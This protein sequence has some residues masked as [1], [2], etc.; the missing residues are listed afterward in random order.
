MVTMIPPGVKPGSNRSERE[1][2]TA[3]EG[4]TDRPDWI[5]LHSLQLANNL[6]S[7]EGE[8]D[9]IVFVPGKG[10]VVIET[11]SPKYVEYSNG[12]WY[13]D[14]LPDPTKDPLQQLSR[15]R[16][17][18]RGFLK[19]HDEHINNIPIA[20][21]L[22][23]TSIARHQFINNSIGDMQF[24]E[25]ELGLA[26]DKDKPAVAIEKLL[27]NHISFFAT[28]AEIEFAPKS[29]T[30]ERADGLASALLTNFTGFESS[31]E[32]AKSRYKIGQQMLDEQLAILELVEYNNHIYFD[33]GAGTGK[34]FLLGE[35]AK[36][37]AKQNKRTLVTC[38][39]YMMAEEL[40][41]SLNRPNI[42]VKD[43]NTLM[44]EICGLDSNPEGAGSQW[45]EDELPSMALEA[46]SVKPA[47]GGYEALCVDE[48]QDIAANLKLIEL[49]LAVANAAK[50]DDTPI[51]WAGDRNQQIMRD[52]NKVLDPA[53]RMKLIMPDTVHVRLRTNCRSVPELAKMIPRV[54]RIDTDI[55][56]HKIPEGFEGGLEIINCSDEKQTQNLAS[57]IKKLLERYSP[58]EIVI[59]SP[60]GENNSTVGQLLE[61]G[62]SNADERSL[63]SQLELRG[64]VGKIRW[65]SIAK[66]K[67]LESP[68]AVI[69]DINQKAQDFAQSLEKE[70]DELL[71]VGITRAKYECVIIGDVIPESRVHAGAN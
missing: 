70:L 17:N 19:H 33:G 7:L 63:I 9:F 6:F 8:A 47:L 40:S 34:S 5:V 50:L 65:R 18:I 67:G 14:K 62:P 35:A 30:H 51:V 11:K 23:F 52:G 2:F 27:D 53:A 44:L 31:E 20:R 54:V 60:F 49:V 57:T 43:L 46:L 22:W 16:S 56:R 45:F 24:F 68:V 71:Y 64:T 42:T 39:N 59:L 32:L 21:M 10:I 48:F 13:L 15:A 38:W 58:R 1:V 4:I 28:N 66:F 3:F 69:T 12:N 36:K 29:F 26:E 41:L 55:A 37:Y 61:R 25:W